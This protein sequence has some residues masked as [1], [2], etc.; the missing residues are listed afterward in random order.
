MRLKNIK[1]DV[2]GLRTCIK[3][4]LKFIAKVS[5]GKNSHGSSALGLVIKGAKTSHGCTTFGVFQATG[6][7][8]QLYT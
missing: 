7:Q 5:R 6:D 4:G 3:F 1:H 8:P 2:I